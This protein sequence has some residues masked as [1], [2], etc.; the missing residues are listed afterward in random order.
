MGR[1]HIIT[2]MEP[3]QITDELLAKAVSISL[4]GTI[5]SGFFITTEVR[6]VHLIDGGRSI[7]GRVKGITQTSFILNLDTTRPAQTLTDGKK[8]KSLHVPVISEDGMHRLDAAF[9]IKL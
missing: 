5:R 2:S 1:Q 4:G 7:V 3:I 8:F 9:K 6:D